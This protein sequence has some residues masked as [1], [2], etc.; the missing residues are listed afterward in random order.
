MDAFIEFNSEGNSMIN[1]PDEYVIYQMFSNGF[2][3]KQ[4]SKAAQ[5]PE[6][7]IYNL[8][9]KAMDKNY[10]NRINTSNSP[11]HESTLASGERRESLPIS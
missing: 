2:D 3:T 9:V 7:K 8:L 5:L 10:E 1:I 6:S 4:I 11:E